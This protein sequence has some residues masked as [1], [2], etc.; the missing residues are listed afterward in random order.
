MIFGPAHKN[1]MYLKEMPFEILAITHLQSAFSKRIK[2]QSFD[3]SIYVPGTKAESWLEPFDSHAC[4]I[5]F[6]RLT[7][8]TSC[9]ESAALGS[10][11]IHGES[12]C[13]DFCV[14]SV[15]SF[16]SQLYSAWISVGNFLHILLVC[17]IVPKKQNTYNHEIYW[18][19]DH[20]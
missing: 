13:G 10:C 7:H 18:P 2:H 17:L 8:L 15:Y 4:T 3:L 14:R 16:K 12:T 5:W 11:A 1:L 9:P 20:I 6:G 19:A